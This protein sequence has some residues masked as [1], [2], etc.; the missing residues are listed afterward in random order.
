MKVNYP[1]TILCKSDGSSNSEQYLARLCNDTFLSLWSFPNLFRDQGRTNSKRREPKG[2]GK[3]VCDL[4]VVFDEYLIIFSDK[5]CAFRNSGDL[6]VDWSRWYKKAV[7]DAAKQL[8]GAERWI[9]ENPGNLYLDKECHRPFPLSIP[10][11]ESAIVHRIVVAHGASRECIEKLGGSG[12]LMI[13]PH[14]IGDMHI[15]TKD[16]QC[17]PFS[18]GQVNPQEGYVHVF[19][20]TTLEIVMRALDTISDFTGYLTKK[21][22]FIASGK[23]A[24]AA[25]EDDL[26]AYYLRGVDKNGEHTFSND[27]DVDWLSIDEGLWN[28]FLKSPQRMAQIK[29]NEISYSWDKLVEKFFHH[30]TTGTSYWM[31]HPSIKEQ[32][33]IFRFLAREDRTRRRLLAESIH[34]LIAKTPENFRA[35]R[36]ILPSRPGDPYYLFLLLPKPKKGTYEEYRHARV[37]LLQRY[38]KVTKLQY[39]NAKDII[40]LATETG[41]SA[42]RSEDFIYYD[43]R[44]WS[45]KEKK[46]AEEIRD[47]L[48][49]LGMLGKRTMFRKKA[50]EYPVKGSPPVLMGM[51]GNERNK[52]CPCGSGR[53]FKKC[54]GAE[55]FNVRH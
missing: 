28:S 27:D 49:Q 40:G 5:Y 3:E 53:K 55:I 24:M 19:D 31:T 35:T 11:R 9:F 44:N 23:L 26:L 16:R 47:E 51:K 38:L 15:C 1:E 39:Q 30:I 41:V 46:E 54:C 21:E 52:P 25:G 7:R 48:V 45:E 22:K 37:E 14:I 50:H 18:I 8:W 20:D 32:E 4:L 12:S 34:E 17:L 42:E 43:G 13:N 33:R 10:C 29:A 36:L 6:Q 2:D